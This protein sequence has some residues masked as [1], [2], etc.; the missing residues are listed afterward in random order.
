MNPRN[1]GSVVLFLLVVLFLP[2]DAFPQ[3]LGGDVILQEVIIK[4]VDY[5][6][7][8]ITVQDRI[9]DR[10]YSA[11]VEEKTKLKA[12]KKLING[13]KKAS[14]KDFE[15]GDLIRINVYL[16]G[17]KQQLREM[18]LIRKAVSGN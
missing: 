4:S 3:R 11:Q 16:G 10:E 6:Q 7:R 18:R 9:N 13:R 12:K 1:L 14:L 8:L 5:E 17:K 2:M 15:V